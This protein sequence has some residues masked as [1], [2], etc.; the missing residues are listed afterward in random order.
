MWMMRPGAAGPCPVD[1]VPNSGCCTPNAGHTGLDP[2][3]IPPARA[4]HVPGPL[5]LY[6]VVVNGL[7]T[8]MWLD[9][10][11][12]ALLGIEVPGV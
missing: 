10:H 11:D 4:D 12:A 5:T 1:N 2:V 9:A 7:A 6:D 3:D 8:Q